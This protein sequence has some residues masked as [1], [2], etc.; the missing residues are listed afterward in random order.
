MPWTKQSVNDQS[1][2]QS[3]HD[4]LGHQRE[5]SRRYLLFRGSFHQHHQQGTVHLKVIVTQ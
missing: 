1:I 5:S 4:R 2:N 3:M